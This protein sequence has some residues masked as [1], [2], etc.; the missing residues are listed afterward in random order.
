MADIEFRL[1]RQ[2]VG[3]ILRGQE[4]ADVVHDYAE[5]IRDIVDREVNDDSDDDIGVVTGSYT[6]DRAAADVTIE[7]PRGQE[8][9]AKH[10]VL[11][12]AAA[13][14]GLEVHSR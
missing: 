14:V 8:L 12:K 7:H 5:R 9:Q 13:M 3:E 10:G 11:T 6:T 4:A 1:D 2:G